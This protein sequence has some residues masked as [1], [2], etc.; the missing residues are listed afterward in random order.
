MPSI[1]NS[2]QSSWEQ[3]KHLVGQ[4]FETIDLHTG[5]EPLRVIT[6]G[7]PECQTMSVL[8]YRDHHQAHFDHL[9]KLLMWEPRGHADMYGC[10]I[11]PPNDEKADLGVVFMHNAGYSTMCGH[12]IIAITKLAAL[13]GWK[14]PNQDGKIELNIDAPCGRISSVVDLS[15]QSKFPVSFAGVPSFVVGTNLEL[16]LKSDRVI[17]FDLSYG[18]A[19]YAYVDAD[20]IDLSL[21]QDNTPEI[22]RLGREIKQAVITRYPNLVKHPF[23]PKLSFLYGTIFT[24][25]KQNSPS[26][27]SKNVCV[28]AAGELDRSPTGSGASG[29]MALLHHQQRLAPDQP[30]VIES[31]L[32]S[33][34]RALYHETLSFGDHQAVIPHVAGN[35]FV[36]G[37][38]SFYLDPN[39]EFPAGFFLR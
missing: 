9:R 1:F 34:F 29:R 10:V 25:E 3:S 27:D 16:A 2:I 30:F 18:G 4:R 12:A 20:Q 22:I 26:A 35:A 31:I 38:H 36:T 7:C 28:F 15:S 24:S 39:D 23:E 19:F 13:L 33:Q 17:N 5:G 8:Q 6:A 11:I 21:D 14:E 37:Q 32:G